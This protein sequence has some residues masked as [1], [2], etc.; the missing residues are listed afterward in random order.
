MNRDETIAG[1]VVGLIVLVWI[2]DVRLVPV[3]GAILIA[4]P[5]V[6]IG[7]CIGLAR[8]LELIG[9]GRRAPR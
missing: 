8:V 3:L 9:F 7:V 2:V 1:W 5:L 4:G 6:V